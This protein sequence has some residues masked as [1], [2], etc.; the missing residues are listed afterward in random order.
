[1]LVKF[2]DNTLHGKAGETHDIPEEYV[3][4][5][6]NLVEIVKNWAISDDNLKNDTEQAKEEEQA[7]EDEVLE[8]NIEKIENNVV[9]EENNVEEVVVEEK[10]IEKMPKKQNKAI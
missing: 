4:W 9:V 8:E 1:M 5:Y 7:S 2:L 6:G 3:I 10:N